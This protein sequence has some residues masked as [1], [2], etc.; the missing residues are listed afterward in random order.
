MPAMGLFDPRPVGS[1][2][3]DP[4][5]RSG[6]DLLLRGL[7]AGAA[8]AGW[9][10]FLWSRVTTASGLVA[11]FVFSAAYLVIAYWLRPAP[12]MSN[13]GI[14]GTMID[15]PLRLSDDKNRFLVFLRVL[16]WPGRFISA[17]VID[18][19]EALSSG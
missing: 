13:L 12:E 19:F 11:A 5:E 15:H 10:W 7:I 6:S 4:P 1:V 17:T 18:L 9:T 3:V 14:W 2:E 8:L 16:L